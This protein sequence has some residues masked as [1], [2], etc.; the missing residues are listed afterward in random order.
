VLCFMDKPRFWGLGGMYICIATTRLVLCRGAYPWGARGNVIHILVSV[1][2]HWL[3]QHTRTHRLLE[4]MF[5]YALVGLL[6]GS[7]ALGIACMPSW[8]A[9]QTVCLS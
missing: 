3:T 9:P 1:L 4:C 7:D 6:S 2:N 8:V 5:G